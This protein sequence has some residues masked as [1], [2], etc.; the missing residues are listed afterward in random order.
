MVHL[1]P[2]LCDGLWSWPQHLGEAIA[3]MSTLAP[4][5]TVAAAR[6]IARDFARDE[7]VV[8]LT[9]IGSTAPLYWHVPA[10]RQLEAARPDCVLLLVPKPHAPSGRLLLA[11]SRRVI[12][13]T[14]NDAR[15]SEDTG[16]LAKLID[17]SGGRLDVYTISDKAASAGGALSNNFSG[18]IS[19][20]TLSA[21]D[22]RRGCGNWE[23]E[24]MGADA[25]SAPLTE[26]EMRSKEWEENFRRAEKLLQEAA[27]ALRLHV[28]KTACATSQFEREAPRQTA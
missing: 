3:V 19:W 28:E 11:M 9:S 18:R 13:I 27:E 16:K 7:R 25:K 12:L 20:Q 14:S 23:D 4:D 6:A 22:I 21:D 1:N 5:E 8:V 15:F 2:T 24:L 26:V 10:G 17:S